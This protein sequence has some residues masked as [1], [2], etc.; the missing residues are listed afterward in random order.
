MTANVHLVR[1]VPK[2]PASR[3]TTGRIDGVVV[4]MTVVRPKRR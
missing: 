2:R 3:G 4:N 1:D